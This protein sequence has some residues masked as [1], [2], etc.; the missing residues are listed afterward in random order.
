MRAAALALAAAIGLGGGDAAAQ[1]LAARAAERLSAL[2]AEV[3]VLAADAPALVG[4]HVDPSGFASGLELVLSLGGDGTMLRTVDLVA[5]AGVPVLG[6]NVGQLGYLT[7]VEPSG[8][9]AA[10]E[11]VVRSDYTVIDRMMLSVVV[12]IGRAHV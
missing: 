7:E 6:V 12:E 1:A 9:D 10:L 11:R 4:H 3:R 5:A 8:L 2:G